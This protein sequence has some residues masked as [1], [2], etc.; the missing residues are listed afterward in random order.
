MI[1]KLYIYDKQTKQ[2]LYTDTGDPAFI[3][4]DLGDDKDFTL[5]APPADNKPYCWVNDRWVDA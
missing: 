2:Y 5:M 1:V 4:K 3:I